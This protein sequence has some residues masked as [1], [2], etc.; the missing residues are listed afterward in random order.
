MPPHEP[1]QSAEAVERALPRGET[2]RFS[3]LSMEE[4]L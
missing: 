2:K 1:D 3:N 4:N